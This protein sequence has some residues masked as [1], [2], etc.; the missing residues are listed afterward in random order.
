M[1]VL[2]RG[3]DHEVRQHLLLPSFSHRPNVRLGPD[4]KTGRG[5]FTLPTLLQLRLRTDYGIRMW[6]VLFK[7]SQYKEKGGFCG[8]IYIYIYTP[9][10]PSDG[11]PALRN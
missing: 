3:Y 2:A 4:V 5:I 1:N 10:I 8:H 6:L 11:E 9:L 7:Y